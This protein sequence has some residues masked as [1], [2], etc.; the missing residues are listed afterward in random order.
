MASVI[1]DNKIHLSEFIVAKIKGLVGQ[2]GGHKEITNDLF[3]S[4]PSLLSDPEQILKESENKFYFIPKE[5]LSRIV[6]EVNRKESG[7]TEINT[8]HLIN[9]KELKRLERIFPV[10]FRSSQGLPLP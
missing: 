3:K 2:L 6:V 8:F 5:P 10:V 7:L 9:P 4:L 1:N